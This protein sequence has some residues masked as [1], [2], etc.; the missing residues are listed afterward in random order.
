MSVLMLCVNDEEG[1]QGHL[2]HHF[3]P[4]TSKLVKIFPGGFS[5]Q[6]SESH[7]V[8]TEQVR[9]IYSGRRVPEE[10]SSAA[11]MRRS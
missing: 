6:I 7:L 11:E 3:R 4:P 10:K 1:K 5:T 2:I 9:E 8:K